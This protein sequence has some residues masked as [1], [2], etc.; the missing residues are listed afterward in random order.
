[1]YYLSFEENCQKQPYNT[2]VYLMDKNLVPWSYL[3]AREA[4]KFQV[5]LCTAKNWESHY[6][7]SR[8]R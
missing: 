6:Y 4:G 1:M 7:E 3:A 8:G 2:S 5:A